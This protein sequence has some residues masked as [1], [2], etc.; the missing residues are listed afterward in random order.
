[1]PPIAVQSSQNTATW[2]WHRDDN[3]PDGNDGKYNGEDNGCDKAE[4]DEM[5][6]WEVYE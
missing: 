3:C 2:W 5:T 6:P 1:M 4:K